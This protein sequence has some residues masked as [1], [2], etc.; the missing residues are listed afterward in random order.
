MHNGAVAH[1]AIFQAQNRCVDS[2]HKLYYQANIHSLS[3]VRIGQFSTKMR[4]SVL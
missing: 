1:Y 3:K 2:A 4:I